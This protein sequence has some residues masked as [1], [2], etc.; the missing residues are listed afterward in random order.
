MEISS[1]TLF[2]I[3]IYIPLPI[4]NVFR[5]PE[6]RNKRLENGISIIF[7]REKDRWM[8]EMPFVRWW[9]WERENVNCDRER[10][11]VK[12]I[13]RF[14]LRHHIRNVFISS[15][16]A[17]FYFIWFNVPEFTMMSIIWL[18]TW[19]TKVN[20]WVEHTYT[21]QQ[22]HRASIWANDFS[23]EMHGYDLEQMLVNPI[24]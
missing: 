4:K 1:F 21:L 22:Q 8:L 12:T 16:F 18:N 7:G 2:T 24:A 10:M 13:S 3:D 9:W 20:R 5:Q 15:V 23:S 6:T 14:Q 17:I 11:R 19:N